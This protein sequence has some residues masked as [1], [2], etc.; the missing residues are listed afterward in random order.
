MPIPL[1]KSCNKLITVESA[2]HIGACPTARRACGIARLNPSAFVK[3]HDFLM[4]GGDKPPT[5]DKIVPKANAMVNSDELRQLMG[6]PEIKKQIE[7]YIDLYGQLQD[8]SRNP[9]KFGLPVQIVGDQV[10]S[11]SIENVDD[12]YK[13]WEKH[14]GVKPK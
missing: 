13:A 7:G 11:G 6:S 2:S 10:L 4:S 8:K 12:I 9:A 1:D 14:L 5:T 3:F